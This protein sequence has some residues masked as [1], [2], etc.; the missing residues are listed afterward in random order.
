VAGEEIRNLAAIAAAWT[1]V[2]VAVAAVFYVLRPHIPTRR[3]VVVVRSDEKRRVVAVA[4][5]RPRATRDRVVAEI[6][7]DRRMIMLPLRRVATADPGSPMLIGGR[8]QYAIADSGKAAGAS[9]PIAVALGNGI[10]AAVDE[11]LRDLPPAQAL[12]S[13]DEI[14]RRIAQALT[15]MRVYGIDV[16]DVELVTFI[17]PDGQAWGSPRPQ[18][19]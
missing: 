4:G 6:D 1:G 7:P 2:S 8:L 3:M 14:G 16:T 11:H 10:V 13:R 9:E 12:H 5:R 19:L 15:T 18:I 17:R